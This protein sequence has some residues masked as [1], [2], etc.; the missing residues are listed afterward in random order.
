M[1]IRAYESLRTVFWHPSPAGLD[2]FCSM[3][4]NQNF[5]SNISPDEKWKLIFQTWKEKNNKLRSKEKKLELKQME[6][7]WKNS[8]STSKWKKCS[9]VTLVEFSLYRQNFE[10]NVPINKLCVSFLV[11]VTIFFGWSFFSIFKQGAQCL[12]GLRN[13][14]W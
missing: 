7:I 14:F 5:S 8:K 10:L 12:S 9:N 1:Q 11:T 4:L 3:L 13:C 6:L 2:K